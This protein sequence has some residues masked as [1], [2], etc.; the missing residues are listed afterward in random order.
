MGSYHATLTLV[1]ILD[2]IINCVLSTFAL[3][4]FLSNSKKISQVVLAT[5]LLLP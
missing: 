3:D 5:G 1:Q 4:T 2:K